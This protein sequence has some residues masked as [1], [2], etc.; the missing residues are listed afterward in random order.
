LNFILSTVVLLP[1]VVTDVYLYLYVFVSYAVHSLKH[2]PGT[3]S[4][5]LAQSLEVP[6]SGVYAIR[7]ISSQQMIPRHS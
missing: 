5:F 6:L 4:L 2:L 3:A 7:L 1:F